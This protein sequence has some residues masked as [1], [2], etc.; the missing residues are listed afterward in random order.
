MPQIF[1]LT[2]LAF[3]L[4]MVIPAPAEARRGDRGGWHGD[5]GHQEWR[6]NRG[7]GH[8]WRGDRG[9]Y[10]P[11]PAY[12]GPVPGYGRGNDVAPLIGGALLGLGLGAVLGGALAPAPGYAAPPP[13][14]YV[15]P[16]PAYYAPDKPPPGYYGY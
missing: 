10:G 1:R 13:P 11:G 6:G 14:Q 2:A 15:P 8:G 7:R 5:R 16:P 12:R 4:A 9:Y 3:A